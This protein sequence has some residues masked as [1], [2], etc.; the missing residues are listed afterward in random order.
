M[1]VSFFLSLLIAC[2]NPYKEAES[3]NTVEA[4]EKFIKENPGNSN[5]KLAKLKIENLLLEKARSSSKLEDYDTFLKKYA[6]KKDSENYKDAF[7]ERM[8]IKWEETQKEDT[9]KAYDTYIEEYGHTQDKTLITARLLKKIAPYKKDIAFGSI[10]KEEIDT[11][12]TSSKDCVAKGTDLNG[13][14]FKTTVTN[15][16]TRAIKFLRIKVLYLDVDGKVISQSKSSDDGTIMIG[17]MRGREH[18]TPERRKAPFNVKDTRDWC[19]ITGDIPADWSKQ[20]RLQPI[21]LVFMND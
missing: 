12:Q 3:Q 8:F 13:W 1:L 9:T 2:S 10:E 20:I 15:N 7:S 6:S 4:Y 18:A 19:Y 21:E 5:I 17:P 16:T 14:L 11:T